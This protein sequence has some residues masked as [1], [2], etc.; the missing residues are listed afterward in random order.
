[1]TAL[2]PGSFDP[3]TLGHTDMIERT[4]ALIDTVVVAVLDNRHKKCLFSADERADLLRRVCAHIN[5]VD[6]RVY[7]GLLYELF[8]QTGSDVVIRG[9]RNCAE[10][11][12]EMQY[13]Q[14][15][16]KVN[17]RMQTIFM[18]SKPEHAFVNS[19]M[20]RE[21]AAFSGDLRLLLPDVIIDAVRDKFFGRAVDG[22]NIRFSG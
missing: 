9:L 6:V 4:A 8:E 14:A 12:T 7:E 18:P 13:A 21:V 19:S 10:F 2:F 5:N 11:E 1:M 17:A 15:F 16:L 20:A 22:D 3:V